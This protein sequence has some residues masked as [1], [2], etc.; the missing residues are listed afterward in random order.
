MYNTAELLRQILANREYQ[1][2]VT[3]DEASVEFSLNS[4]AG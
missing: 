4:K 2:T 1:V 3:E